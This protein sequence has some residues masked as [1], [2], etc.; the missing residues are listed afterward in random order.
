MKASAATVSLSK[1]VWP[2]YLFVR[3]FAGILCP[4][5][6]YEVK[7]VWFSWENLMSLEILQQQNKKLPGL[8][9]PEK[10]C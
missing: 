2:F 4:H 7:I 9:G 8:N 1:F 10:D 5:K 3:F 6:L